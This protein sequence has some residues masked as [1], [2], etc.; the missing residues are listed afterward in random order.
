MTRHRPLTLADIP[1]SQSSPRKLGNGAS[2][3]LRLCRSRRG[4]P[5]ARW[6]DDALSFDDRR[7][8]LAE[9]VDDSMLR[10][11]LM[12]AVHGPDV[13]QLAERR[14]SGASADRPF[15]IDQMSPEDIE[16][17]SPAEIL[18]DP[19]H[20]L[21]P[22][23]LGRS[24]EERRADAI[25]EKSAEVEAYQ[26]AQQ[27][28]RDMVETYGGDVEHF[29]EAADPRNPAVRAFALQMG[30]TPEEGARM[31]ASAG[32]NAEPGNKAGFSETAEFKQAAAQAGRAARESRER[33]ERSRA[34]AVELQTRLGGEHPVA[35]AAVQE[36]ERVEL[37][38]RRGDRT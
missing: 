17:A 23:N 25:R 38:E 22:S 27:Y 21:H 26:R 28:A 10:A 37:A 1:T 2:L 33:V 36:F 32:V 18:A 9:S 31:W 35:V 3:T 19:Q 7:D 12:E 15:A 5:H 4:M 30:V 14:G 8:L 29:G 34:N 11:E 16:R 20:P 6:G 13:A 24:L